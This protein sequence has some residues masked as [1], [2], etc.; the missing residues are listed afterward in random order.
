[1]LIENDS[2]I[3]INLSENNIVKPKEVEAYDE[4][5]ENIEEFLQEVESVF[6]SIKQFKS[7]Y[8]MVVSD[9]FFDYSEYPEDII[10]LMLEAKNNLKKMNPNLEDY[11]GRSETDPNYLK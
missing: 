4:N 9:W 3:E 2:L 6:Q 7:I 11:E 10:D 8:I 5:E 1:M